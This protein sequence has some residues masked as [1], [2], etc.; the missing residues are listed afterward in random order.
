MISTKNVNMRGVFDFKSEEKT[1]SF[2]A[3]SSSI[4]II[5]EEEITGIGR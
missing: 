2:N 1:D 4:Y 3:L 5:S